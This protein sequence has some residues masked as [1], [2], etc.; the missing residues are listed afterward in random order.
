M[1]GGKAVF[2]KPSVGERATPRAGPGFPNLEPVLQS[3]YLLLCRCSSC[4][5]HKVLCSELLQTDAMCLACHWRC[6]QGE[7]GAFFFLDLRHQSTCWDIFLAEP[8]KQLCKAWG[9]GL[10]PD[11]RGRGLR[12]EGCA[13]GYWN[14]ELA[15]ACQ[16]VTHYRC[17]A[18]GAQGVLGLSTEEERLWSDYGWL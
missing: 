11:S 16:G 1:P 13:S 15:A 2:L 9:V 12:A 3:S 4:S 7:G 14:T 5:P 8:L 17:S 18:C 10:V 6:G